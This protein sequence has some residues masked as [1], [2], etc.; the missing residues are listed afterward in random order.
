MGEAYKST[1]VPTAVVAYWWGEHEAATEEGKKKSNVDILSVS[2]RS[3]TVFFAL[4]RMS[5]QKAK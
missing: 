5:I 1:Q 3:S 2:L 4:K